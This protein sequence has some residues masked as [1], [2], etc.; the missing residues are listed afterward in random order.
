MLGAVHDRI[1]QE[2]DGFDRRMRLEIGLTAFAKHVGAGIAPHVRAVS[3]V[4][5]ELDVVGVRCVTVL[6]DQ[7]ELVLR[8]IERAHAAIDLVPDIALTAMCTTRPAS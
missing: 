3:S 1:H 7:D 2:R 6:E 4:L 5:A 8:A